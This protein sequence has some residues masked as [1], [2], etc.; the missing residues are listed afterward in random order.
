MIRSAAR[1]ILDLWPDL[2]DPHTGVVR[3]V[4][5]FRIDDDEPMFV[6]YLSN[7]SSTEA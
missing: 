2:V 7:A 1:S 4:A 5:E 6:H 3:E